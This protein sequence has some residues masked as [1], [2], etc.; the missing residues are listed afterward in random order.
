MKILFF[1]GHCSLC[2]RWIDLMMRLDHKQHIK[3]ASLQG[4]SAKKYL[5]ASRLGST[6]DLETVVYFHDGQID[7]R[8]T[9][10]LK[11]LQDVGGLWGAFASILL[12]IPRPLR[13][14]V[15]R[16]IARYRYSLFGRRDT[17]RL[18]TP[19]EKDRILN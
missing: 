18:P 9:G 14:W 16:G 4:E 2:N 7:D 6:H 10:A 8:S 12:M 17:C 3:F 11:C 19:E 1:D 13:D 5:P 15:Y